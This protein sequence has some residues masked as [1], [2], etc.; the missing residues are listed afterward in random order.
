M[1]DVIEERQ[2][3]LLQGFEFGILG[4]GFAGRGRRHVR[5]NGRADTDKESIQFPICLCFVGYVMFEDDRGVF[6]GCNDE[7]VVN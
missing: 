3:E 2:N 7:L 4:W 5:K 6:Q 1:D